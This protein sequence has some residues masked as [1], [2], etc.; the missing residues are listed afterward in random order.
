MKRILTYLVIL[1]FCACDKAEIINEGFDDPVFML[2]GMLNGEAFDYTA[3]ISDY[4]LFTE[5]REEEELKIYSGQLGSIDHCPNFCNESLT[6]EIRNTIL[7]S[8]LAE[9]TFDEGERKFYNGAS[10]ETIDLQ[11][12]ELFFENT[13]TS[14]EELTYFWDFGN[15]ITSTKET[16]DPLLF[17]LPVIGPASVVALT[18]TSVSG[19][20]STNFQEITVTN[21]P[22]SDCELIWAVSDIGASPPQI[23]A[24]MPGDPLATFEWDY[25][26]QDLTEACIDLEPDSEAVASVWGTTSA[27]CTVN[28]DINIQPV[29]NGDLALCQAN[30]RISAEADMQS[31]I[32]DIVGLGTINIVYVD[33][34]GLRY[35]SGS[36]PEQINGSFTI[37]SVEDYEVNEN[38]LRTKSFEFE[39]SAWLYNADGAAIRLENA[40]G[41]WA[42]AVD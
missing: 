20:E 22:A 17:I 18:V 41:R 19:C 42:V 36:L 33:E 28:A 25:L 38:G 5:V 2:S 35:E 10:D 12:A 14:N 29:T 9:N 26:G 30:F 34:D 21:P 24:E 31:E 7:G 15:G 8:T 32:I 37:L 3:G 27:G 23:C 40:K 39:C 6:I 1:L 4:Y 16:P 13:S 11:T